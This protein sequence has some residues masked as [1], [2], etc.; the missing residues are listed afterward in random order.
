[1]SEVFGEEEKLTYS[2]ETTRTASPPIRYSDPQEDTWNTTV[3]PTSQIENSLGE[4]TPRD[5]QT[6]QTSEVTY[7]GAVGDTTDNPTS[8]TENSLGGIL[9][10]ILRLQR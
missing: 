4:D 10:E 3:T 6:S 8:Q 5:S 2:P 1:M 9:L 7:R